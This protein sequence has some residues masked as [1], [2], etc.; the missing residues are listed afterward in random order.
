LAE[1]RDLATF[2]RT[3]SQEVKDRALGDATG[4][5]F[6]ENAFVEIVTDHLAEIGMLDNPVVC[7]HQGRF[8]T[9]GIR[10]NGYAIPDDGERLDLIVAICDGE[11]EQRTVP[12][13]DISRIAGQAAR[14][15]QA[16]AR[17]IHEQMERASDAYAMMRRIAE[18]LSDGVR[19]ARVF[20][21][22]DGVS[23]ARAIN[24]LQA[25][26]VS[27]SF[28]IYDLRRLM[29]TMAT[30]QTREVIEI[31]LASMGLAPIPC[32]AMPA[33]SDEYETYLAIVPGEALYRMYEEFGP[34]LL[35]Y[36]VRA[37][38]QAAGKVNRGIR[39]TLRNEPYHFMAYN[40]GISLTVD[41]LTTRP[42]DDGLKIVGF[43]GL[44]IVNG[45]QTTASI[46]RA[47]KRDRLDL[48]KV[49]VAAKITRLPPESV[50]EMV[51]RISRFANTQNVIQEADFSS[52]EPFHIAI[53]RLS[54][55][56]W[57]PGEQ[58]RWFYERS[59]GQYSTAMNIE[60]TTPARLKAFRERTP[61]S[62]R[63]SK[64]DLAKVL[65][66]WN[67]LPHI[68]SGGAQKNFVSFMKMLRDSRGASWE[69]DESFFRDAVAQVI[70][71]AAAARVVRQEGFPAYRANIA[72]YL[73]AYLS[74]RT[75]G[76]LLLDEIWRNQSVSP[77]LEL[78][79]R[80]WSHPI[81]Q[82]IQESAAGRN[83]TEWCKKEACW[84]ALK[85]ADFPLPAR[86]PSE[87]GSARQSF[88]EDHDT[89]PALVNEHAATATCM[90]LSAE[91]WFALHLWGRR[92]GQLV[93]WQVGIAHTLSSYAGAGW[94]KA[95]TPKQARQAIRIIEIAKES[96]F[97]PLVPA[98]IARLQATSS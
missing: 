21:L 59:R 7:F 45:G 41:E 97:D 98:D 6:T 92:S 3:F 40:N 32:V 64:T 54:K 18:L 86:L 63:F 8:G 23:A 28:E 1:D 95:P 38:L 16:A 39:D 82:R 31:D 53:E 20:V 60:G 61:P 76:R 65:N 89:E 77:E 70:L 46:H 42:G 74:H 2:A 13:A 85:G 87:W 35:E 94:R 19:E 72:C 30:G 11:P 79:I 67:R 90:N 71:F 58:S 10:L 29:R 69:P 62:Q 49:H 91:A 56:V 12:T 48:S 24:P 15:I 68:V 34:R 22:T 51:P 9:G 80:T 55:S 73:V 25:G 96:G 26:E 78:L 43:R 4:A 50:E 93:E 33:A 17:G 75:G 14:A 52:N 44:Q 66:S 81:D 83:V 5:E 27:V 88:S 36:N 84:T 57:C 47:R 37:F